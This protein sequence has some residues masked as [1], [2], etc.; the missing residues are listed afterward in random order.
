MTLIHNSGI[1]GYPKTGKS[2]C[3]VFVTKLHL[4]H[5]L[6]QDSHLMGSPVIELALD[7]LSHYKGQT[8]KHWDAEVV[9]KHDG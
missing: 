6:T 3:A 8:H 2:K 7:T 4:T 9:A 5:I 1:S